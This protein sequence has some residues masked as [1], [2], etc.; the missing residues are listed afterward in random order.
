MVKWAAPLT[1]SGQ[2]PVYLSADWFSVAAQGLN[3]ELTLANV[4]RAS[5]GSKEPSGKEVL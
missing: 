3:G 1:A 4:M 5:T 2:S